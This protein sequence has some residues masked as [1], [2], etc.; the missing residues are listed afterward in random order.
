MYKIVLLP[1]AKV[2]IQEAAI[3]YN[4]KQKG[5]GKKFTI[6][7]RKTVLHISNNPNLSAIRYD[8]IRTSLLDVFPFLVHYIVDDEKLII[9]ICAVLHTSL[10]P[11]KWIER[12]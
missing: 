3:W 8:D 7:V 12:S 10:N 5:L 11:D 4:S 1:L 9:T 6:E 2:D